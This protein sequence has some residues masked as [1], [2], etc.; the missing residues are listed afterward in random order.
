AVRDIVVGRIGTAYDLLQYS[1]DNRL[2]KAPTRPFSNLLGDLSWSPVAGI[3]FSAAGQ[4]ETARHFLAKM[5]ASM[6]LASSGNRLSVGYTFTDKRYAA[7][8][9]LLDINGAYSLNS[10]WSTT[11]R[12][13]YDMLRKLSQQTAVG[14]QYNHACWRLGVEGYRINRRSGTTTTSNIGFHLLL[15]FKG[16]G[17]VGS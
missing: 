10:R 8:A 11:G 3:S 15:E 5:R 14:L 1:V 12:W 4:Y 7:A 13:Q 17:S 16:L 2:Q 6:S 9:K